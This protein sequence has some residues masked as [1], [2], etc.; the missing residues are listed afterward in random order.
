MKRNTTAI[1][2]YI[3]YIKITGTYTLSPAEKP[4]NQQVLIDNGK[5]IYARK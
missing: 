1:G 4:N 3:S 5:N 2:Q